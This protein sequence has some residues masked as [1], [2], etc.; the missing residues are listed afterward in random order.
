MFPFI[1][2]I[3]GV[4]EHILTK[5]MVE[6][7]TTLSIERTSIVLTIE[8]FCFDFDRLKLASIDRGHCSLSS[9]N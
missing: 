9:S 6:L 5:L 2:Q 8:P 4:T 1:L 7:T 3:G